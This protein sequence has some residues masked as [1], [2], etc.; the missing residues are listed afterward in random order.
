[1]CLKQL[2]FVILSDIHFVEKKNS[3]EAGP[4]NEAGMK[5][6]LVVREG[7]EPL[8]DEDKQKFNVIQSFTELT[9]G[10]GVCAGFFVFFFFNQTFLNCCFILFFSH[11][12]LKRLPCVVVIYIEISILY[13]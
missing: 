1:M 2:N 4:A 5:T 11:V 3:V 8:S 7:N 10:E 9:S 6:C 12:K 13:F